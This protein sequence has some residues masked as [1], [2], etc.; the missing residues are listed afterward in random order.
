MKRIHKHGRQA[1]FTLAEMLLA[2]LILLLVSTIVA[3]GVP[4]AKDAYEKAVLGADAQVLLST[5]ASALRNEL[6]TAYGEIAASGSE[7]TYSSAATGARAK[8]FVKDN[9]IWRQNYVAVSFAG[10]NEATGE[11][12][13]YPLLS[14]ATATKDLY[15]AYDSVSYNENSGIVTFRNL[16]VYRNGAGGGE[17]ASLGGDDNLEIRVS[18][19]GNGAS[20]GGEG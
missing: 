19:A 2:V 7:V 1:G 13:A 16:K 4:V 17:L 14:E 12:D 10:G 6:G 15:V 5:T 11:N 3:T 8:L 20:G 9:V 18:F